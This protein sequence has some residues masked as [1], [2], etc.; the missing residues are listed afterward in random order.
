MLASKVMIVSDSRKLSPYGCESACSN[1]QHRNFIIT[2]P[3]TIAY[4]FPL[5]FFNKAYGNTCWP[6]GESEMGVRSG[7]AAAVGRIGWRLLLWQSVCQTKPLSSRPVEF[8]HFSDGQVNGR[9]W[10]S[11]N[12][13]PTLRRRSGID[14]F[15]LIWTLMERNATVSLVAIMARSYHSGSGCHARKSQTSNQ[16]KSSNNTADSS[17]SR[18]IRS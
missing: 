1:Y 13:L 8:A 6:D 4:I 7:W 11:S 5:S 17:E 18:C 9:A 14:D 15:D 3:A 10:E 2:F 16:P 12:S